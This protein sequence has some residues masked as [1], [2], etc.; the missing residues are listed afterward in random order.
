[1]N[2]IEVTVSEDKLEAR[3]TINNGGNR[4]PSRLEIAEAIAKAGVSYG[5]DEALIDRIATEKVPVTNVIIARG[6]PPVKGQDAKLIWYVNTGKAVKPTITKDGKADFKCL[7]EFEYVT[8]DH[9]LVSK[10][11]ATTGIS[12]KSVT[13]E[14]LEMPGKDIPLPVGKNTRISQD[15]LTLL[16]AVSGCVFGNEGKVDIDNVYHIKG[17]VDFKTGNVKFDG[18]L[19]ISGDV[20]S[21]F[22]VDATDSIYIEGNVEAANVYSQKGD[23]VVQLGILGKKRAKVFAGGNLLCRF[24]QDA[25]VGV[26]RDILIDRYVINSEVSSGG[27]VIL[28]QNEGLIR[29]GK[30]LAGKGLEAIEVGSTRNIS[31]EIGVN[32]DDLNNDDSEQLEIID[33]VE[34]LKR[35]LSSLNKRISFFRLLKARLKTLSAEKQEELDRIVLEAKGLAKDIEAIEEKRQIVIEKQNNSSPSNSIIIRDKLHKGVTVTIG[36]QQ[37]YTDKLYQNVT[38]YRTGDEI[39]IEGLSEM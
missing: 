11:P 25:T 22:R 14:L 28:E 1:M 32:N 26:K 4:F 36:D 39:V 31:T 6:K 38:I 30:I 29:G 18:K 33:T 3:I 7:K 24:I 16:A 17:D 23:V 35:K 13:G 9:E 27:K 19:L 21:G 37:Y 12:G 15:G 10:L 34:N 2:V 20:R 8:K 5:I